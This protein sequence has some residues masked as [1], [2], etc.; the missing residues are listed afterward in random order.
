MCDLARKLRRP[1]LVALV[2]VAQ[3]YGKVLHTIATL[4]LR[5]YTCQQ[6]LAVA[7]LHSIQI[8]ESYLKT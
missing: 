8:M 4:T 3:C 6:I 7:L 2:D 1:M 5:A